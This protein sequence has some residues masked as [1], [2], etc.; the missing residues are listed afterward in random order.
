MR[1]KAGENQHLD[2]IGLLQQDISCVSQ[3]Y[4]QRD[5]LPNPGV[6]AGRPQPIQ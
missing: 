1:F 5:A 4:L 6:S 3:F 2:G